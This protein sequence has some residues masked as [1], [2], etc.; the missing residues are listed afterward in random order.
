MLHLSYSTFQFI[1]LQHEQ[2]INLTLFQISFKKH[3]AM[4]WC[5]LWND[6]IPNH[7]REIETQKDFCWG[8]MGKE[9]FI[10][11]QNG[12]K[13]FDEIACMCVVFGIFMVKFRAVTVLIRINCAFMLPF[14]V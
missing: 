5:V 4:K 7:E 1:G 9:K 2:Y 8:C 13:D 14:C 12:F 3:A 10:E 6:W 11:K